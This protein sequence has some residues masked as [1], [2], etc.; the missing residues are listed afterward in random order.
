MPWFVYLAR[1]SDDTLYCGITNDVAARF[2]AHNAGKGARY[3]RA[4]IP[5]ELLVAHRCASKSRALKLEYRV[6]QLTRAEKQ[7]LV[8]APARFRALARQRSTS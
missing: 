1:C 3:T 4:R 2:V 5:I 8:A 7:R 6:K